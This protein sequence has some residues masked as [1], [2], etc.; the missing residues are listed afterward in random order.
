MIQASE[1][2]RHFYFSLLASL[3][4]THEHDHI[5]PRGSDFYQRCGL[6]LFS[7]FYKER[8]KHEI[9]IT[10]TFF[11]SYVLPLPRH[12]PLREVPAVR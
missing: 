8:K 2:E 9:I 7:S 12:S 10:Y 6:F 11:C 5:L 4:I 1:A 3:I